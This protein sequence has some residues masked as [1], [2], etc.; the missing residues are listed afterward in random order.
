MLTYISNAGDLWDEYTGGQG[1]GVA[2]SPTV[3]VVDHLR[4]DD[5]LPADGGQVDREGR[6]AAGRLPIATHPAWLGS[7]G[8][9]LKYGLMTNLLSSAR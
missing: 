3:L 5:K 1:E 2:V 9:H 4:R 6:E 7:S 8:P